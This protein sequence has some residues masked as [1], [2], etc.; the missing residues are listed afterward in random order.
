MSLRSRILVPL[1]CLVFVGMILAPRII[2]PGWELIGVQ[3]LLL[4]LMTVL[5]ILPLRE[6]L[7]RR[8][9]R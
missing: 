3:I 1:A 2:S 6:V 9:G 5:M 7:G 8:N 4:G